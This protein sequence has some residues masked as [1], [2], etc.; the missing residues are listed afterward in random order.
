M[1]A[2]DISLPQRFQKQIEFLNSHPEI[3]CLGSAFQH[4]DEN[5][6]PGGSLLIRPIYPLTTR[7]GLLIG[8]PLAH[9]SVM[10]RSAIARQLNGYDG[11][12]QHAEDYELWTRMAVVTN[13]CS[14][15][16]MLLYYRVTD[17]ERIS[18]KY[19]SKQTEL[20]NQIRQMAYTRLFGKEMTFEISRIIQGDKNNVKD[21]DR[22]AA[23]VLL[24]NAYRSLLKQP[25]RNR[26]AE[27]ELK[28]TAN[29]AVW[30]V[31]KNITAPYILLKLLIQPFPL[32]RGKLIKRFV[33]P[34]LSR[35]KNN[36]LR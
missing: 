35:I 12:Y 8:C 20:T 10:F 24:Y 30:S 7:F 22:L 33:Y 13:I 15:A 11:S 19:A 4:I 2:D 25:D 16:D 23:C 31:A 36:I 5:E 32:P 14:L 29:A 17:Q 28:I 34:L 26:E 6:T 9:P 21:D 27:N 3:G 18:K 1:D